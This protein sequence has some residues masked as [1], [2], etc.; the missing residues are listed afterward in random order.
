MKWQ[1]EHFVGSTE[2]IF[3]TVSVVEVKVDIQ[4]ALELLA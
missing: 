2:C 3:H 4:D 1:R